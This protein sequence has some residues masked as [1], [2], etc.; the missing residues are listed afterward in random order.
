MVVGL[1]LTDSVVHGWDLAVAPG[2]DASIDDGV[3]EALLTGP[4]TS[5]TADLRAPWTVRC[6]CSTRQCRSG[7]APPRLI[8]WW[9]SWAGT[10]RDRRLGGC[11]LVS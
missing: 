4:S 11:L 8:V 9:P 1:A 3:A 5:V 6:R 7:T 10:T 2:Q